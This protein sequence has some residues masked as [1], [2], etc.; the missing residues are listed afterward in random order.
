MLKTILSKLAPWWVDIA[1]AGVIVVA[2]AMAGMAFVRHERQIGRNEV[3]SKW[4][5]EKAMAASAK[6]AVTQA[7]RD[8]EHQAQNDQTEKLNDLQK[9]L[10]ARDARVAALADRLRKLSATGGGGQHGGGVPTAA[11]Q[12]SS[13]ASAGLRAVAGG[14]HLVIDDQGQQELAKLAV[15]A[16]D[17]GRQLTAT[18]GML[19]DC[20]ALTDKRKSAPPE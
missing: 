1:L 11:G 14:D 7:S 13:P 20:Q 12:D 19:A 3:Q 4:D 6:A 2:L 18:A 16:N 10:D 15:A 8:D 5:A 9:T 17:I